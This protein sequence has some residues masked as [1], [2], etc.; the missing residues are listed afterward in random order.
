MHQEIVILSSVYNNFPSR[1]SI[2]CNGKDFDISGSV[3]FLL[4][5]FSSLNIAVYSFGQD[6]GMD[7]AGDNVGLVDLKANLWH[8]SKM[9]AIGIMDNKETTKEVKNIVDVV[10]YTSYQISNHDAR[11]D[12]NVMNLKE[13]IEKLDRIQENLQCLVQ[14]NQGIQA[15]ENL[16]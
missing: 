13:I 15:H 16:P 7:C 12:Y 14:M 2:F 6:Q 8:L 9:V 1:D 10:G 4:N 11:I 5:R 3:K